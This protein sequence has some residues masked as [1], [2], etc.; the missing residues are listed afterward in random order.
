[1][2]QTIPSI[3]HDLDNAFMHTWYTIRAEAIDNILESSVVWTLLKEKGCFKTQTGGQFVT[4]TVRY[5][6]P[7][8]K[9]VKKG[10]TFS[11]GEV[12]TRTMAK[13]VW[14]Y[15]SGHVQ[16]SIFDDQINSGPDKIKDYIQT[17]I[18]EARE[19]LTQ[20]LE[21]ALFRGYDDVTELIGTTTS[22]V[23]DEEYDDPTD[24]APVI[25]GINDMIP[26]Y[27][28]AN[29]AFVG[30]TN[31][32]NY[33]DVTRATSYSTN[34]IGVSYADDSDT[35]PQHKW[36]PNYYS[37]NS[38]MEVNLVSDMDKLYETCGNNQSFPDII[39]MDLET[40]T[41]YKEFAL[42][43]SQIVKNA[44]TRAADLGF[45]VLQFRGKPCTWSPYVSVVNDGGT[46]KNQVVMINSQYCELVYDP[47]LWF[48]ATNWKDIPLQGERIMH[49][50]SAIVGPITPQPRRHGRL[51]EA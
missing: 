13:W 37:F 35:G 9:W 27:D 32:C 38:P 50:L 2:A 8:S 26:P 49:I 17:R 18:Q 51:Y 25:Q 42:D 3:T 23:I 11:Q 33:G 15:L 24:R 43:M 19:G 45:E 10:S 34:D 16:R 47:N 22:G 21:P 30:E 20:D 6:L 36:G 14:R 12:E 46:T 39:L 29:S 4:R 31:D 7:G 48:D 1:M 41:V 44:N 28:Y 40:F 5:N